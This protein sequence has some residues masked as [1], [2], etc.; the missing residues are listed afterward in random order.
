MGLESTL[1]TGLNVLSNKLGANAAAVHVGRFRGKL[2]GAI[3]VISAMIVGFLVIPN[4]IMYFIDDTHKSRL[5]TLSASTPAPDA[6]A[7][8]SAYIHAGIAVIL[9][10]C[11]SF[12]VSMVLS[13]FAGRSKQ[14][15]DAGTDAAGVRTVWACLIIMN[16]EL[17]MAIVAGCM[18]ILYRPLTKQIQRQHAVECAIAIF[19]IIIYVLYIITMVL[20]SNLLQD[21]SRAGPASYHHGA[22]S[23]QELPP[24]VTLG[25]GHRGSARDY[26]PPPTVN[27]YETRTEFM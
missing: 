14:K 9:L 1:S 22:L 18:E 17:F 2:G 13:Y 20:T 23:A 16:V 5:I 19:N 7:L 8:Q 27:S 25:G 3:A 11:L 10:G 4:N 26:Y 21:K 12:T 15:T 24:E 6:E